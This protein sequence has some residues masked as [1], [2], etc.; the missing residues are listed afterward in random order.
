MKS[1]LSLNQQNKLYVSDQYFGEIISII[2]WLTSIT[3]S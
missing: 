1:E 2:D 3:F